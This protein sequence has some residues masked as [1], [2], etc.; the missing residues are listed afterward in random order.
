MQHPPESTANLAAVRGEKPQSPLTGDAAS[1]LDAAPDCPVQAPAAPDPAAEL[2]LDGVRYVDLCEAGR[3][4]R[5]GSCT[6]LWRQDLPLA[7]GE[8][9]PATLAA[10]A[11]KDVWLAPADAPPPLALM[12][13]GLGSVWPGMGRELYDHVPAA[14]AMMDRIAAVAGWDVLGLM[15]ETDVEKISRTR[16]QSPY[17]FMVE[18][19]QWSVLESLGLNP[20]L[21]C[22]HSLGELIALCLA[23]IYTPEV[24]WYILDTRAAHMAELEARPGADTGMMAVH[25]ERSVIDE[26]HTAW[27]DLYIS[28]YNT[29]RQYILSGPRPV[30]LEARKS[31]RK[32]RIPAMMLNVSLAFHHPG[33]RVL[34]DL[35]LRRLGALDMAPPRRPALSCVTTQFYPPDQPGICRHIADLDEHAVRWSEAV[36]AI[37]QRDG[38]RHFLELG[39]QD[40][41]CGLVA[42]NEPRALC[43]AVSRKGHELEA[44]RRV[45]A[46]LYALG[47]LR[48]DAI[49]ARMAAAPA[50]P[51]SAALRPLPHCGLIP[52]SATREAACCVCRPDEAEG[53]NA[54]ATPP[55][56]PVP[57]VHC[58]P[59]LLEVLS[60]ASGRPVAE[61]RPDMD[62]RY[63]LALRSSRFPLI[64]EELEKV[65]GRSVNFED[66]L[67]AVTVGD[68]ARLLGAGQAPAP[69]A[70]VRR[71]VRIC[72]AP[73]QR[74]APAEGDAPLRPLPLDPC[75]A[76]L[77]LA[78]GQTLAV[79]LEDDRL[80]PRL[81][82]GLAPLGLTLAVPARLLA[83]CAPLTAGARLLPWDVPLGVATDPAVAA[84]SLKALASVAGTV[85][86]LL[87][88]PPPDT[89]A[90]AEQGAA[91]VD[92]LTALW[93]AARPHGLRWA[94]CCA[95]LAPT[96]E[97]AG[98]LLPLE[99]R[100]LAL[101]ARDSVPV[102]AIRLL[103]TGRAGLDEWG[104]LLA[105]ELLRGTAARVLWARPGT[106]PDLPD[107][108]APSPL[109]ERPRAFPLVFPDPHPAYRATAT[110]FQGACHFSR[111]ADPSLSRHG[112]C[113]QARA[114]G[115]PD[116]PWL[117]VSR[118]LEAL[119]E[120]ARQLLPWLTVCG[121]SDLRFHDSPLLP[122]GI[123]RECR[124]LVEAEPWLGQDAVMTRLCR[125]QL[126]TRGLTSNGRHTDQYVPA[127]EGHALLAAAAGSV[128]PLWPRAEAQGTGAA[129]AAFYDAAGLGTDWR[130]LTDFL[131]LD[132]HCFA[133]GLQPA[134]STSIAPHDD[135][136][137]TDALHVV[138][139]LVQAAWLAIAH[140]AG[141][142]GAVVD[143]TAGL[144]GWRLAAAGFI[145]WR[146]AGAVGPWRL[147]LRRS[148][149]DANLLRFDA[150]AR[151]AEGQVFLTLHHLEFDRLRPEAGSSAR[152]A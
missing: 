109:L 72:P 10:L 106:L 32:R 83:A 133:A 57:A 56:Q 98:G 99:D 94:C 45:C 140:D 31:L 51:R 70:T 60:R 22:G 120:G 101:G 88:T 77:P 134:G 113:G 64:V 35:S 123:T 36:Q 39:P 48:R 148:W 130:L 28:N 96:P 5:L 20:A 95:A 141:A 62:L 89:A 115:L 146:G 102:R 82:R 142:P 66:L 11:E 78:S 74:L 46:R 93:T 150:Q 111:Y 67:R 105:R 24:G 75:G 25:A 58:P 13:C 112:G 34:R 87:L 110:L 143:P 15:D 86:G 71:P 81:L 44:L 2:A 23:G 9:D 136:G 21:F 103:D 117:P 80:L 121:F 7:G 69:T 97:H 127:A 149:A 4:W 26:A 1:G 152:E 116:L 131:P 124:V 147:M 16:W 12:C 151:D 61:L 59:A 37:W 76:G 52:L 129:P 108:G 38:I 135:C 107:T 114:A 84:A 53:S 90:L 104:D 119:L 33:M 144:R 30:L 132:D 14:R 118:A 63:D 126:L 91:Q 17:L 68:L 100:L 92:L 40:T 50:G 47:H 27:P 19:A 79:W 3:T 29:P 18:L 65:L 8:P 137:Y 128:P 43:L 125:G 54:P 55:A 6:P 73:L 122:P 49:A 145:R 85:D 138:E 42:D 139:G 41:L